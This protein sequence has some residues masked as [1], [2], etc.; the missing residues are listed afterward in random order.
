MCIVCIAYAWGNK[1]WME[2][3][4]EGSIPPVWDAMVVPVGVL[5]GSDGDEKKRRGWGVEELAG[6]TYSYCVWWSIGAYCTGIL[7]MM[8]VLEY[9]G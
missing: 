2:R 1:G 7:G 8:A 9:Q 3:W 4:R 5:L 6:G